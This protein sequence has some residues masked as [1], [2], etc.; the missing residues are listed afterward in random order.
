MLAARCFVPGRLRA[1]S[2]SGKYRRAISHDRKYAL[3]F[4]TVFYSPL[5]IRL[6]TVMKNFSVRRFGS[7][8]IVERCLRR[9]WSRSSDAMLR[10]I[11]WRDSSNP[12]V[13]LRSAS[14][15]VVDY[16]VKNQHIAWD[17]A[18]STKKIAARNAAIFFLAGYRHVFSDVF[19][20]VRKPLK[21]DFLAKDRQHGIN[22]G[23]LFLA[24]NGDP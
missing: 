5:K 12:H 7:P 22:R 23:R 19:L 11:P 10:R 20:D 6:S 18:F 17:H 2:N 1:M 15:M 9:R 13:C 14:P 8:W 24:G 21:H 3:C 16:F 4:A